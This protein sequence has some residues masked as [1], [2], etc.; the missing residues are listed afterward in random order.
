M[1]A[2]STYE[3]YLT[4]LEKFDRSVTLKEY[5]FFKSHELPFLLEVEEDLS[6]WMPR[7][8]SFDEQARKRIREMVSLELAAKFLTFSLRIA[9]FSIR[10]SNLEFILSGALAL[11]VDDDL[12]DFRDVLRV[13]CV[14][15]DAGVRLKCKPDAFLQRAAAVATP[16]RSSLL[17]ENF[18]GGPDYMKSIRSMGFEAV[19][20]P[21][22]FYY[23]HIP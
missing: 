8:E 1:E 7:F 3:G 9:T 2:R 12:L 13:T 18:L 23:K 17:R 4:I 5:D 15:Y 19:D 6:V 21:D 20:G 14:L 10:T 16:M 22:G 11:V